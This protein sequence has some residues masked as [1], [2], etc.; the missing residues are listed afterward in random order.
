MEVH[1]GARLSLKGLFK[2]EPVLFSHCEPQVNLVELGQLVSA[3]DV[4]LLQASEKGDRIE[5]AGK[6]ERPLWEVLTNPCRF[7]QGLYELDS[8]DQVANEGTD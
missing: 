1:F 7:F 6:P 2:L 8:L 3:S 4:Y 5:E